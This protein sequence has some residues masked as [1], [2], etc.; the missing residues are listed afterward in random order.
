M[1]E[2]PKT[3]F[4]RELLRRSLFLCAAVAALLSLAGGSGALPGLAQIP[5]GPLTFHPAPAPPSLV[6]R[7]GGAGMPGPKGDKGD[8]GA[9]GAAASLVNVK[10]PPFP[11]LAAVGDGAADD[12]AVLQ[13]LIDYCVSK[14]DVG[15]AASHQRTDL[16]LPPG[17]YHT[18]KTLVI[19]RQ[20][21]IYA[22]IRVIGAG[23]S[24]QAA[25]LEGG[26][27]IVLTGAAQ[28]SVLEIERGAF[29]DVQV[30]GLSLVMAADTKSGLHI[31]STFASRYAIKDVQITAPDTRVNHGTGLLQDSSLG[32]GNGE[33]PVL[34]NVQV[35]NLDTLFDLRS[36]QAFGTVMIS[37]GGI[38]NNGGR[39]I[40]VGIGDF[41]G[42]QI[43][44]L[45][46]SGSCYSGPLPN[47]GIEVGTV[48]GNISV[49]GARIEELDTLFK[50][51]VPIPPAT[52]NGSFNHNGMVH[53]QDSHFDGMT[54]H[55]AQVIGAGTNSQWKVVLE[56]DKFTSNLA[57]TPT[58]TFTFSVSS[59]ND[60]SRY[61]FR[62]CVFENFTSPPNLGAKPDVTTGYKN[63]YKG[64]VVEDCWAIN[65][66]SGVATAP[67]GGYVMQPVTN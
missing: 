20:G 7:P 46:Y 34:E 48:S 24:P 6:F 44:I 40:V 55:A 42:Y 27:A 11:F 33:S 51:Q 9:P 49:I 36:G 12:T 47:T 16:Y 23:I 10:M 53:Y 56:N 3:E 54:S 52:V 32:G 58:Q 29:R 67:T 61:I 41:G 35:Y 62:G 65:T 28:D 60:Q 66:V 2:F 64:T 5:P 25:T 45:G 15:V 43:I 59:I 21:G 30:S 39:H 38:C 37:C 13:A 63:G 19:D 26:T 31:A 50:S 1:T 22:G 18:T 57:A 14:L 17:I 4:P 8:P